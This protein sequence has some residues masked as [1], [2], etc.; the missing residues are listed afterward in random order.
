MFDDEGEEEEEE[1]GGGG[2]GGGGKIKK[3]FEVIWVYRWSIRIFALV[4]NEK[5]SF[6]LIWERLRKDL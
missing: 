6:T 1:E 5:K 2:G 3:K 4:C